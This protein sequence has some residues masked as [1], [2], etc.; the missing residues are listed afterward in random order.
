MRRARQPRTWG[1][2]EARRRAALPWMRGASADADDLV[3]GVSGG[4]RDGDLVPLLP[5]QQGPT[6][7]RLVG[8]A[9]LQRR[10][11]R[12]AHDR[13]ALLA[14]VTL[15]LD[16]RT[17]LDMAG[18]GLSVDDHRVLDERREGLDATLDEGLLV[19]GILVL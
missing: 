6:H 14:V 4:D 16:G 8:D 3:D 15:E 12:G 13:V 9:A 11:L 18:G 1:D 17:D 19:L 5:A 10:G 7:G 2:S